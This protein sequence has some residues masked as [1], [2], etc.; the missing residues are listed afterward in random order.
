MSNILFSDDIVA[1]TAAMKQ[2]GAKIEN[3]GD[4]TLKIKG[5]LPKG[6]KGEDI[7]IYGRITALADVFDALN[8]DRVYKEKWDLSDILKY[9]KSESGKHFDPKLVEI[10][11]KNI[12]EFIHVLSEYKD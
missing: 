12:D 9:I 5:T 8:S 2:L 6:L 7:H 3:I 4:H 1:T 11:F 10:F